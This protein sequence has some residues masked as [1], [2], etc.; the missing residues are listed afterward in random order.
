M[1]DNRALCRLP[2]C[3]S[4]RDGLL[5]YPMFFTGLITWVIYVGSCAGTLVLATIGYVYTH[6]SPKTVDAL[7]CEA[8][9]GKPL[10]L[11]IELVQ[12]PA[13]A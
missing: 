2:V 12:G 11:G 1:P 8:K 13:E 9:T 4:F 7:V 3:I 5:R 10:F 6:P